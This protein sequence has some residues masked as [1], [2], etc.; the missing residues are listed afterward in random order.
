MKQ[1]LK[2]YKF[3]LLVILSSVLFGFLPIIS[4]ILASIIA[5]IGDCT[6]HEGYTNPCEIGPFDLGETLYSMF[7]AGWFIFLSLPIGLL[8]FAIG[9]VFLFVKVTAEVN[10]K[11]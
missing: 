8:G 1:L 5:N 6:L 2:R 10:E 11:S 9:T 4:V 3:P 7:V